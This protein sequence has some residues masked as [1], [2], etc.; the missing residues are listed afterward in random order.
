MMASPFNLWNKGSWQLRQSEELTHLQ[1]NM[2]ILYFIQ[3]QLLSAIRTEASKTVRGPP[4]GKRHLATSN[5]KYF[6]KF[7][8]PTLLSVSKIREEINE[9]TPLHPHPPLHQLKGYCDDITH[10]S[11][12][13]PCLITVWL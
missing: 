8:T 1:Y 11:M 3:V 9:I 6:L 10:L 13:R 7:G 4:L 12:R 2:T 5:P